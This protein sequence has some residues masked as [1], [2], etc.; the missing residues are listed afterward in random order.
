MQTFLDLGCGSNKAKGAFGVDIHPYEG[1]DLV[2]NV[3]QTPWDL[4][5]NHFEQ[6]RSLHVIEHVENSSFFILQL[7]E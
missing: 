6:I 1:V 5:D 3:N 7:L 2:L 4:P